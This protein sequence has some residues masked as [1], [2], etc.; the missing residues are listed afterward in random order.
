MKFSQNVKRIVTIIVIVILSVLLLASVGVNIYLVFDE[1]G[2]YLQSK[3]E[4][5]I[6]ESGILRNNLDFAKGEN[7]EI[8]YDLDNA[9]YPQ[10]IE[11]YAIDEIAGTGTEF[12]KALRLMNEFAPRLNHK[13]DYDNSVEMN[14]LSLLEYSL[15]NKNQGINCRNKAQILNEM[16]LSLGIYSRKVWIMPNSGYDN[17]CHVVNEIWDT[18]LNKWV[19]LDITNNEYWVDEN[20]TPLSILE[21]RYKGAMQEFCTPVQADDKLDDLERLKDEYISDF[22]YIM[23]NLTYIQ[24]CDIYTV[25]ES[26]TMYLLY[27]ENL[28]TDYELIISE[29]ASEKSPIK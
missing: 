7:F 4:I 1:Y 22:L 28:D 9:E 14:A 12:E 16:C 21:I 24:Y 2:C 18:E 15:D 26:D 5:Y 20:G 3:E 10:L 8:S 27:P 13:S 6:M 25:G 23:K 11:T 17:D 29:E 19:M